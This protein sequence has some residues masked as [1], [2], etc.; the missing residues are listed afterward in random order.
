MT[1]RLM[2]TVRQWVEPFP[3][4]SHMYYVYALPQ[5]SRI[6]QAG[7]MQQLD[8]VSLARARDLARSGAARSIR[9]AAGLSLGEVGR[10]L[11]CP[12]STILRWERGDRLP[13]G[14]LAIRWAELLQALINRAPR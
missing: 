12:A 10:A 14:D 7:R 1:L 3:P 8:V 11:G 4:G 9:L 2:A 6:G 13:R 5:G